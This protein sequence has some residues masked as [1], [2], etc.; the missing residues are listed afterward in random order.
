MSRSWHTRLPWC[1]AIGAFVLLTTAACSSED[2]SSKGGGSDAEIGKF[3]MD[4]CRAVVNGN[5]SAYIAL[6]V[7]EK[8]FS[9]DGQYTWMPFA[10]ASPSDYEPWR[11]LARAHYRTQ[12]NWLGNHGLA[13]KDLTCDRVLGVDRI[14]D[15]SQ[16]EKKQ[17]RVNG[18]TVNV[19]SPRMNLV[20]E[21]GTTVAVLRGRKFQGPR[22]PQ[23]ISWELAGAS[24][25][26][27]APQGETPATAA[28]QPRTHAAA[29]APVEISGTVTDPDG[30]SIPN[31]RVV[32]YKMI[33]DTPNWAGQMVTDTDG[34][35]ILHGLEAGDYQLHGG[36]PGFVTP[37]VFDPDVPRAATGSKGVQIVLARGGSIT[38]R[39]VGPKGEPVEGANVVIQYG[40]GSI[41]GAQSDLSETDG[42]FGFSGLASGTY[43]LFATDGELE[44]ITDKFDLEVLAGS[45]ITGYV[46]NVKRKS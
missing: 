11:E 33:R 38:G 30:R 32:Y 16:W 24:V 27:G 8:D 40:T 2:G 4:V 23:F 43:T 28:T 26:T 22:K 46:L 21:V 7:N 19:I 18:V 3:A 5:E 9:S 10:G 15:P 29:E 1:F 41:A 39:V 20:L 31:A 42:S 6:H 17:G 12:M 14:A 37:S 25:A 45:P 44:D 13:A 36:A 35:F 34:R